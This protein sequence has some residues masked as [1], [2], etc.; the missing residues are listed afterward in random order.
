M[1][2]KGTAPARDAPL[3]FDADIAESKVLLAEID[4]TLLV[5]GLSIPRILSVS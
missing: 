3:L 2:R 4:P 1:T 5:G